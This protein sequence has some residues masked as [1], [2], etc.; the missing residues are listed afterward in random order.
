MKRML[1]LS[2]ALLV[3]WF[4]PVYSGAHGETTLSANLKEVIFTSAPAA[5]DY[6]EM[7]SRYDE[8]RYD[9]SRALPYITTI[10]HYEGHLWNVPHQSTGP[11]TY[12]ILRSLGVFRKVRE[13]RQRGGLGLK[14]SIEV[15]ALKWHN[16]N[17]TG[18]AEFH[19]LAATAADSALQLYRAGGNV[20]SLAIDSALVGGYDCKPLR[21]HPNAIIRWMGAWTILVHQ[22]FNTGLSELIRANP[23]LPALTLEIG[24][25]EPY[26]G[27]SVEFHKFYITRLNEELRKAGA[28]ALAFYH[29]D[30]DLGEV[31]DFDKMVRDIRE[32][33]EFVHSQ[34]M[35]FGL[36]VNG[37][38]S[39][40]V[41]TDN[42]IYYLTT[43]NAKLCTFK[44][45]G[46]LSAIDHLIIQSWAFDSS[47][48]QWNPRNVPD[49]GLT[50]TNFAI[51]ALKAIA[52]E[53]DCT[54]Y[55]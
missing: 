13:L 21:M 50:H 37:D 35:K 24:D 34:G 48:R 44:R 30:T 49:A 15:G 9:W 33:S 7:L 52:G 8:P 36:I 3:A 53:V 18:V 51:H 40:S 39:K 19:G 26:P 43:A 38:D 29:L 46:L 22:K 47:G 4:A 42:E 12:N 20:S 28:P 55:P 27:F 2:P 6:A 17:R 1:W 41:A 16:C 25:I 54:P 11:N 10:K 32:L 23:N 5:T 31:A 14:Q 45:L